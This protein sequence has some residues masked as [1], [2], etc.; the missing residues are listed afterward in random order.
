MR[1]LSPQSSPVVREPER[2]LVELEAQHYEH[3]LIVLGVL[4]KVWNRSC[5][6]IF[7][8]YI[9]FLFQYIVDP[10]LLPHWLKEFSV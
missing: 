6:K 4:Y 2:L 5:C 7:Y 3:R 10:G 1:S 8:Y 9:Y